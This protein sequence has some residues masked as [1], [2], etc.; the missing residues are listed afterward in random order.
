MN[1]I[2]LLAHFSSQ[3]NKV[4]G[5][6]D[7][8]SL[9]PFPSWSSIF[10]PI[11]WSLSYRAGQWSI[12]TTFWCSQAF[13][14]LHF[15]MSWNSRFF[16]VRSK[17]IKQIGWEREHLTLRNAHRGPH[18]WRANPSCL[19]YNSANV[20]CCVMFYS[21]QSNKHWLR[22]YSGK[23]RMIIKLHLALGKWLTFVLMIDT[24]ELTKL[25]G[26]T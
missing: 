6:E 16:H 17:E 22:P 8:F 23:R 4:P 26:K 10:D 1:Y 18:L 13:P 15:I 11:S 12:V 2:N 25:E 20:S 21:I 5:I 24:K 14:D 9:L 7:T 19:P 3:D